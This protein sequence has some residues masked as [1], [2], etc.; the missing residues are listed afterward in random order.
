MYYEDFE[1]PLLIIIFFIMMMV[2]FL[3]RMQVGS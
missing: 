3:V 2:A 1:T